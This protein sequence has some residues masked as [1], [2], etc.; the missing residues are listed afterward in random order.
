MAAPNSKA[1][2]GCRRCRCGFKGCKLLLLLLV[3]YVQLGGLGLMLYFERLVA[4]VDP[5]APGFE[6]QVSGA[7]RDV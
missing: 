4:H 5:L 6:F 2:E 7:H 3:H 1:A